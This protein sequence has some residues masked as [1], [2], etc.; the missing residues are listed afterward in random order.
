M[1]TPG[2]VFPGALDPPLDVTLKDVYD[3]DHVGSVDDRVRAVET[4][5]GANGSADPSSVDYRLRHLVDED[6]LTTAAG[7][8]TLWQRRLEDVTATTLDV[9]VVAVREGANEGLGVR[10]VA[11]VRCKAAVASLCGA[12]LVAHDQRTLLASADVLIDTDLADTVRLRVKSGVADRVHWTARGTA[13][14][15]RPGGM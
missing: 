6:T 2:T 10:L 13:V 9:T 5:V 4:K 14:T 8:V 11:T 15:A 3:P 1:T 12:L 7:Y